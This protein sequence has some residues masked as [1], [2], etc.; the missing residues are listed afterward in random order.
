[1]K[2][3][4]I[5]F[6]VI[7]FNAFG[8]NAAND[9]IR[10]EHREDGVFV[11]HQVEEEETLYSIA[12]RYNGQASQITKHNDITDH[13]I[14]IGQIIEVLVFD[15]D[16]D[17]QPL[18]PENLQGFHVIKEGETLYSI[19]RKYNV[20]VKQIKKWNELDS[21]EISLGMAL[22]VEENAKVQ[23]LSTATPSAL[24]EDPQAIDSTDLS[25]IESI[26]SFDLFK[27]YLV[28]TGESLGSIAG[29]I[30]VRIDSLKKWNGLSSDYLKIGQLLNYREQN[31]ST[32]LK[33]VDQFEGIHTRLDEDGFERVYEE[34]IASVIESMNSSRYLA[35]HPILPIGTNVEVRNLMN[36][37]VVY[38]KIVGK[39]PNTGLNKNL[40]IRLSKSA[41]DQLGILDTKARVEVSYY[42][43]Q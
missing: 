13:T 26:D 3:V 4:F 17:V 21:N 20:K 19:S 24:D 23:E 33:V 43:S 28:Q 34:G 5:L 41:Y 6:N 14:D 29:K 22:R 27:K 15:V 10:S 8:S 32:N 38:V 36:N 25:S 11:I 18:R 37:Q 12:R 40:L 7:A 30:G 2:F 35:L 31:D 9:S 16:T 42:K 1:M 39:L